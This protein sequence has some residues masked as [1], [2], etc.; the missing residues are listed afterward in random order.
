M[1][2]SAHRRDLASYHGPTGAATAP[3]GRELDILL[4]TVRVAVAKAE[5]SGRAQD[6]CAVTQTAASRIAEKVAAWR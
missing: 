2:L 3:L 4:T 1:R 6:R 5:E